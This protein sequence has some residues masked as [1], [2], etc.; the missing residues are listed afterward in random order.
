MNEG[1]PGP[2]APRGL[3]CIPVWAAAEVVPI[4]GHAGTTGG[5]I[6]SAPFRISVISPIFIFFPHG[7]E[8]AQGAAGTMSSSALACLD[9]RDGERVKE[10]E[11]EKEIGTEME[12][13]MC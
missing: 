8:Q 7:P 1:L 6:V 3:L 4:S 9:D 5:E 10:R 12:R 2:G 13:E 11:R